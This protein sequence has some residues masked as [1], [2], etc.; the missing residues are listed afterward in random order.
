MGIFLSLLRRSLAHGRTRQ[1]ALDRRDGVTRDIGIRPLIDT[2]HAHLEVVGRTGHASN[3]FD[4]DFGLAFVRVALD[5]LSAR[6]R[7]SSQI[8]QYRIIEIGIPFEFF[9]DVSFDFS[10]RSQGLIRA[11]G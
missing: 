1:L 9:L 11:S 5:E 2:R 6:Q 7:Y 8:L 10:I 4:G 3:S